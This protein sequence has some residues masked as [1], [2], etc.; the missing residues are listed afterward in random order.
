MSG[1]SRLAGNC[2]RQRKGQIQHFISPFIFVVSS[3]ESKLSI[4]RTA[5]SI[6]AFSLQ[7]VRRLWTLIHCVR[8]LA[9]SSGVELKATAKQS[10]GSWGSWKPSCH[11]SHLRIPQFQML[12]MKRSCPVLTPLKNIPIDRGWYSPEIRTKGPECY[13]PHT[14]AHNHPG[15]EAERL[16]RLGDHFRDFQIEL[17]L[18]LGL[19]NLCEIRIYF[20]PS[21]RTMLQTIA[22]R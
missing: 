16:K 3:R 8:C 17:G 15:Q 2:P 18:F 1:L 6:L 20:H 14:E 10:K 7:L 9:T 21:R 5:V 13:T 4:V 12:S 22:N 19:L 11:R